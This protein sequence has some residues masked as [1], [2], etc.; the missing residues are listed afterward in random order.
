MRADGR[1]VNQ[2]RKEIWLPRTKRI[3][4]DLS[5]PVGLISGAEQ[6]EEEEEDDGAEPRSALLRTAAPHGE[7]ASAPRLGHSHH[8]L[9]GETDGRLAVRAW[10]GRS[11][12]SFNP[13][14]W[15]RAGAVESPER[16][17]A[18]AAAAAAF[19]LRGRPEAAGR[20][21][22]PSD[23]QG[24]VLSSL[25]LCSPRA[26]QSS[27]SQSITINTIWSNFHPHFCHEVKGIGV[28]GHL[29]RRDYSKSSDSRLMKSYW[30][31][32]CR[33]LLNSSQVGKKNPKWP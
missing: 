22:L 12:C 32:D 19:P 18:A 2:I 25:M 27:S 8:R 23:D 33:I 30:S 7:K 21:C 5:A 14:Q 3:C 31:S 1:K 4:G 20:S 9:S 15:S 6:R 16:T 13:D 10:E 29:W 26:Q 24:K 28:Q 11:P 17:A